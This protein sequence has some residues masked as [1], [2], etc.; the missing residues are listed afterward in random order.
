M[1]LLH[2]RHQ[3]RNGTEPEV[4]WDMVASCEPLI[5]HGD[6]KVHKKTQSDTA[7]PPK[8]NDKSHSSSG[9]LGKPFPSS[10]YIAVLCESK[11]SSPLGSCQHLS[12][13]RDLMDT[14]YQVTLQGSWVAMFTS[15]KS[16]GSVL[17]TP[18]L[19]RCQPVST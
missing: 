14:W 5:F 18:Y 4:F 9:L 3:I 16:S 17:K 13:R 11:R 12:L 8:T 19:N 7:S 10:N 6:T 2:C 1:A 15:L